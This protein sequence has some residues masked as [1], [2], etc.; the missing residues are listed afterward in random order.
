M[1]CNRV[2]HTEL[3]CLETHRFSVSFHSSIPSETGFKLEVTCRSI[4]IHDKVQQPKTGAACML[5][6]GYLDIPRPSSDLNCN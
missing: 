6:A 3:L 5:Q 1:E 2:I 4:S